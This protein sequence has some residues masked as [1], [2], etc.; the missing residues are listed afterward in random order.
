MGYVLEVNLEYPE[1]LYDS[2]ND[3]PLAPEKLEISSNMLSKC[4]SDTANK[5]GVKVD[6]VNKLVPNLRDKVK[7]CVRYFLSNFYFF[8]K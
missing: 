5:Y 1:N 3:Y 7:V 2:H 4:C 6:G 8:T